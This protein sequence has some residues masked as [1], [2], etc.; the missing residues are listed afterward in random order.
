MQVYGSGARKID[1]TYQPGK[2]KAIADT[3]S[4]N[5]VSRDT[6]ESDH[7][8]VQVAA[9][10]TKDLNITQLLDAAPGFD[11]PSELHVEQEN[12]PELHPIRQ[13]L[14]YGI[15][16]PDEQEARSLAAQATKLTI[17]DDILYFVDGKKSG[18]N[19]AAVPKTLQR[20]SKKLVPRT[21]C[22][23]TIRTDVVCDRNWVIPRTNR[24]RCAL[25]RDIIDLL[26]E[27][28]VSGARSGRASLREVCHEFLKR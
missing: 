26:D 3:L 4:R 25:Y 16:P 19:Q 18:R 21:I 7:I 23:M 12:D 24:A 8:P 14:K 15:L 20:Y 10:E 1:I 17:V 28:S 11:S 9:V 22:Q 2:E 5:P 27:E 13:F 6:F